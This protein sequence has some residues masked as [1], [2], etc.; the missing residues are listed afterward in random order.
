MIWLHHII[1]DLTCSCYAVAV[2]FRR[3]NG[4]CFSAFLP[5]YLYMYL[6]ANTCHP[7]AP[8]VVFLFALTACVSWLSWC[9]RRCWV[10]VL[11]FLAMC[12]SIASMNLTGFPHGDE[13]AAVPQFIWSL[14]I[15][16]ANVGGTPVLNVVLAFTSLLNS[17]AVLHLHPSG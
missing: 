6:N 14:V 15:L 11:A 3:V 13:V 9:C 1:N 12:A 2:C 16:N 5:P 4:L 7:Y 17:A 10:S 8:L